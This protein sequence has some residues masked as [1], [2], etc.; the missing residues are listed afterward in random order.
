VPQSEEHF[1][2]VN[3]CLP[4]ETVLPTKWPFA[5]DILKKQWDALPSQRILA[6]QSQYFDS[7]GPN[8]KLGLF[9]QDGYL[10][11]D[12]TNVE[13]ILSTRFDGTCTL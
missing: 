7:I 1:A 2:K 6:F 8:M 3:G 10:T 11:A 5:L 4:M 13:S 9:G 12:P